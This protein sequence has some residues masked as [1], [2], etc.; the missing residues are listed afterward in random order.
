MQKPV[1]CVML[2]SSDALYP[3][4]MSVREQTH[5]HFFILKYFQLTQD[6]MHHS[7]WTVEFERKYGFD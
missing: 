5:N 3:Q 4:P 1:D 7:Q 2:F 6:Y